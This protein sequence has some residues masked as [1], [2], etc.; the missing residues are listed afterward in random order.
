MTPDDCATINATPITIRPEMI[1]GIINKY[2]IIYYPIIQYWKKCYL[3]QIKVIKML[4][5]MFL[6]FD[7]DSFQIENFQLRWDKL[8]TTNLILL[9]KYIILF[10]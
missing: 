3:K 5:L 8:L 7:L 6:N 10:F 1:P 4:K 2:F 9:S